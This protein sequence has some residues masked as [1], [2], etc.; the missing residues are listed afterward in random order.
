[1]GAIFFTF[2]GQ[3]AFG[4]NYSRKAL[5]LLA[6]HRMRPVCITD[7]YI[8]LIIAYFITPIISLSRFALLF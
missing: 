7:Q 2:L 4:M 8:Y 6:D 5:A 3:L 1:M